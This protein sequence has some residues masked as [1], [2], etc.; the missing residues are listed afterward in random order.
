MKRWISIVMGYCVMGLVSSGYGSEIKGT[1][2]L[3][4]KPC[5]KCGPI[6]SSWQTKEVF[7]DEKGTFSIVSPKENPSRQIVIYYGDIRP[8][9]EVCGFETSS[10]TMEVTISALFAN[11]VDSRIMGASFQKAMCHGKEY[12]PMLPPVPAFP[13]MPGLPPTPSPVKK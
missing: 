12:F 9:R 4:G 5:P 3:N 8:E 1:V 7:T 10:S 11:S 2:L 13:T 6:H